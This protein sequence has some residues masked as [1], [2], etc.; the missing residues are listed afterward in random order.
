MRSSFV[1]F[2]LSDLSVFSLLL[3]VREIADRYGAEEVIAVEV[4]VEVDVVLSGDE[5]EV[6][7]ETVEVDES[8]N[9]SVWIPIVHILGGALT[10]EA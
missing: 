5:A 10:A 9:G 2:S 3:G 7:G 4:L 6:E 1:K 8:G